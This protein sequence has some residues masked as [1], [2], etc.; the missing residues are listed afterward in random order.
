M[1]NLNFPHKEPGDS[2]FESF[3]RNSPAPAWMSDE[4]GNVLFM[5]EC[6]TRL[7]NIDTWQNKHI[8]ELFPAFFAERFI[9]SDKAV[10]QSGKPV[11]LVDECRRADGSSG[12]YLLNKMV[13][14]S[15]TGQR[16]VAGQAID[17]TDQIH[18][19]K[20]LEQSNERF[21]II[22][23]VISDCIWDCDITT[24]IVYR[25]EALM[26]LTG[27]SNEQ[28]KNSL[29]W[30]EQKTH[31]DDRKASIDKFKMALQKGA[32]YC[33][34]EYRFL[35]ADNKYR[36]FYDKGYI[37]YQEGKPVRAIGIVYDVT[38]SKALEEK[39]MLEKIKQQRE[40]CQA[41]IAA[42]DFVSN[43]LSKELHDN[44]NQ[45]LATV[46]MMLYSIKKNNT[47]EDRPLVY[48]CHEYVQLAME[49]IR[50]IS[51][52]LNVSVVKDFGLLTCIKEILTHL[53]RN[54]HITATFNC[55]P[56][57]EDKL[58]N[59]QKLMIF[60]IVQEQVNNII[61]HANATAVTIELVMDN[62][63]VLLTIKDNG[64]GFTCDKVKKGIGLSNIRNRVEAFS[65]TL[66]VKTAPHAG[67]SLEVAVPLGLSPQ[68]PDHSFVNN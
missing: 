66:E 30:W 67:F 26:T 10:L 60:R 34:G 57:L 3:F 50:K 13:L 46:S 44:V 27:Y 52:S 33:E 58:S 20:A 64:V 31:P 37:L 15:P 42:Q 28:I 18:V 47:A 5:N 41:I 23:K 40:I 12:F 1:D 17:I 25:S 65:G 63:N 29:H 54:L 45:I 22:S 61:K 51:R 56:L 49:E 68:V 7:W 62:N 14:T 2:L 35:C 32:P 48:Q 16:I 53:E 8:N 19:K 6:A 43:E 39:L 21:D 4:A 9:A 11:S 36:H 38:E 59:E 55:C 24:G